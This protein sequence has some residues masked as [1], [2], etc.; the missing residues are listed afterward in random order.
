LVFLASI[1][2]SLSEDEDEEDEDDD[3][4]EE[5]ESEDVEDESELVLLPVAPSCFLFTGAV[6]DV[7]V[8]LDNHEVGFFVDAVD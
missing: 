3:V 4:L 6:D 7:V 1:S 5:D 2:E 8:G